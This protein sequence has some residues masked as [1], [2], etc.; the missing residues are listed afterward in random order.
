MDPKNSGEWE[1]C[2]SIN[3]LNLPAGW[4]QKSYIGLT[5]TTGQLADNHDIIYLKSS[6]DAS[7]LEIVEDESKVHFAL[8][9]SVDTKTKFDR[10]VEVTNKLI[11]AHETLDHHVEHQLASVMDHIKNLIGKIE[12]REDSSE[13]RITNL[14]GIIKKV[15]FSDLH[16]VHYC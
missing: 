2:V 13:N 16:F 3:K 15:I 4:V 11:D 1:N 6:S 8:E 12:K 9:D 10:L 14:E 7:L 5:A